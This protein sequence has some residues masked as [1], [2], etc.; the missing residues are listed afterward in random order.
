M[1]KFL[2]GL[3]AG[4][5]LAALA[6]IVTVFSIARLG[7]RKPRI[8][9]GGT[10]VLDI[11][12]AIPEKLPI[13][14]PL[15]V[16]RG[17]SPLTV[18]EIWDVLRKA[19]RD[20]RIEAVLLEP[21]AVSAGWAK[22]DEIRRGLLKIRKAGKPVYAFLRSPG[23]R[24]YY[25]ASAA[26]RI[27]L[28][29]E[30]LLNVKG[31]RAE[32]Q[33][34]RR[35]LEKAG[36]EFEVEHA[37]K[38]KDALDSFVRDGMSPETREVVNSVLDTVY[39]H[40]VEG[41]AAGRKRTP[42]QVRAQIDEG[43]FLAADGKTRGLVDGLA[44]EDDVVEEIKRK[45]KQKELRRI[46]MRE[47]ARVPAQSL[48]LDGKTSVALLVGEGDILSGGSSD[49][50]AEEEGIRSEAFIKVVRQVRD[51]SSIR[52][53]ILRV[54]S[55]GG[56]ATASDEILH[57]VRR[58]AR[59]KPLVVSMSDAAASGGYMISMTGDPVVAYPD[60][61]TGSIG[62]IFGKPNLGGLYEKLGITT[63][64]VKRG[65][66]AD[67][68]SLHKRLDAE[69]RRKLR[70][71]IAATYRSF[72]DRVAEGRRRPVAEIEPLAEGRVWMGSQA[73][74]NGLVDEE[75]G[76]DQAIE[77]L[78]KKMKLGPSEGVHLVPFPRRRSL[79][80]QFF[81]GRAEEDSLVEAA[82]RRQVRSW[83]GSLGVEAPDPQL[84][85]GG[86]LRIVPYSIRID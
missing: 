58:L 56:D 45:L 84:W 60:T 48:G 15:P 19:E 55:P 53:V 8:P 16:F 11:S 64:V 85:K 59:K 22:L 12:G 36:I 61:Y 23:M 74:A 29:P 17:H 4:F 68:D 52:G 73:K 34:Y 10:L 63:E 80:E 70:D 46:G 67:I 38:Y 83:L 65:K 1:K 77:V 57:E 79:L 14:I 26:D 50:F 6:G 2:L 31:L 40:V 28:P 32:V 49:P 81:G 13:D 43:P 37:G 72:L 66:N 7:A 21:R 86:L 24:E 41:L 27:F 76:L 78:K 69:G 18:H 47:Y 30:D 9:A 54:N 25:L 82:A 75:G 3:L 33:F 44:Y 51:D 35:T 20:A 62:V 5:A 71:G 42:E 39:G